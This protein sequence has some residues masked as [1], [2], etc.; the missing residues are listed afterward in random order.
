MEYEDKK[1]LHEEI[2]RA[3]EDNCSKEALMMVN[4]AIEYMESHQGQIGGVIIS[5]A[6]SDKSEDKHAIGAMAGS[7]LRCGHMLLTL[8]QEL[9][10]RMDP[11]MVAYF[12]GE[13]MDTIPDSKKS[14]ALEISMGMKEKAISQTLEEIFNKLK[15]SDN[16]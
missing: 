9:F 14:E 5:M 4:K 15:D 2:R 1:I 8:F 3:K 12:I 10:E 6:P 13:F 16:E 11:E 7:M